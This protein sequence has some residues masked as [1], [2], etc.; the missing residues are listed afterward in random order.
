MSNVLFVHD[1]TFAVCNGSHYTTESLSQHVIDRYRN[2]FGRVDFLASYRD[3]DDS[4]PFVRPENRVEGVGFDLLPKRKAPM[5]GP[6]ERRHVAWAVEKAD[7]LVV[8]MPSFMG[9]YAIRE[10]R[11]IGKP[12][13]IEMVADPWDAYWNHGPAG[14]AVA[15][16]ITS[17][18]KKAC[19]EAG[20][21]LYVTNEFLQGRY[22][23]Q[24]EQVACSD[25][26]LDKVD[27]G[28]LMNRLRRWDSQRGQSALKLVSVGNVA[29]V[30]KGHEYVI[31]ALPKLKGSGRD[32]EYYL[33]GGGDQSRLRGIADETGVSGSVHFVGP[34]PHE[35]VASFL[36]GMDVYLQPSLQE[37]LPRAVIEA[38]SC[39]L[40]VLGS[41]VGGIPELVG[42]SF[43]FRHGDSDA[44][45]NAIN[46]LGQCDLRKAAE[47]NVGRARAYLSDVLGPR[48]DEFYGRF[49]KTVIDSS[50]PHGEQN[51]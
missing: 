42:G 12:Y 3:A 22:P 47:T 9:V 21:V 45:A 44:V 24:G 13:L 19:S 27:E 15:P 48:R 29:S 49:Y 33:V 8:R 1:H 30:Y 36:A 50:Q 16:W 40:P 23:T 7:C 46:G 2:W 41:D 5:R 34:L 18:T 10:A 39:G 11:R 51:V 6:S 37:G 14:K 25:V 28:Q 20:W 26:E 17:Q 4:D 43:V 32:Y 38:M 35:Q 31:R